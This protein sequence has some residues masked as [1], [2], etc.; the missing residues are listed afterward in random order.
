L[1][2]G[3]GNGKDF[4][5]RVY[6]MGF[7]RSPEVHPPGQNFDDWRDAQGGFRMD[8]KESLDTFTLQGDLYD[9]VAGK[10]VGAT[11]YTPPYSQTT[12]SNALLSGG[13]V[14]GRWKRILDE[15]DDI[16]IQLYYDRTDRQA[17]NFA[18]IRNTFDIDFLQRLR[19]PARQKLSWGFGARVDPV[20][21]RVVV[22]GLQFIPN[23]RIDYLATAFLQDE[24]GLVDR[25]PSL[26]LGTKFLRTDF[27]KRIALGAPH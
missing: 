1:R 18:E 19:L 6:G 2:Y 24:I 20:D 27:T 8:W 5:Y 9:E 15:G 16:Q 13:N 14:L 3:G 12:D 11:S 21:D 10:S 26:V 17:A 4:S 7:T 23:E 22:S 25:R